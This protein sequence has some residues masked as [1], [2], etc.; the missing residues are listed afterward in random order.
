MSDT[1]SATPNPTEETYEVMECDALIIGAGP[2]GL[3][4]AIR[5]AQQAK[6]EGKSFNICVLEKGAEVGAH[7]LAGAVLE[8][9]ALNELLPDWQ[10]RAKAKGFT[11]L[12]NPATTDHFLFLTEKKGQRLPTP[13]QMHNRGN[14]VLSL[15]NLCRFLAQEAESLGVQIF[16]GFPAAE[17]LYDEHGAVKGVRTGAFGIA[18]D[19]SKKAGYQPPMEMH[20]KYTLIGEGCRGSLTKAL[21][22]KFGLRERE[23]IWGSP[24]TYGLGVKELWEIPAEKHTPG[25]VVHTIGWP[26]D[27]ATYGGGFL[28]HMANNQVAVG[29]VVGLDYQN[30]TLSPFEEMQR[31]KTH[32]AIREVLEGG[33]RIAY[34]A[35]ALNEGGL[36]SLPKLTFP[37]G[38]LMGCAAGFLNV[39][40]IKGIHNAMWSG[41]YLAD[42][43]CEALTQ[44]GDDGQVYCEVESDYEYRVGTTIYKELHRARN[45]RPAMR[46]GLKRGLLYAALDT[47]IL[48]GHAPWTFKH[49]AD[50]TSLT[51]IKDVTNITYPKPDGTLTF[52]L[53]SSVYLS[54]TN[55]EEDQPSHLK[56]SHSNEK[57]R[58]NQEIYGDPETYYCPA[59]VYERVEDEQGSRIHVNAQNCLHCKTCDIKDPTQNIH[60]VTPEGGGGPNY[61][62]M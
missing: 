52:D 2:S 34:G 27:H 20:A 19:G 37:G 22:E 7:L 44:G 41:I 62:N 50:H 61:P 23:D 48:R 11:D 31:F 49:H 15:G 55:H 10:E 59:G 26:L 5:L 54:N 3:A 38:A 47:Y 58:L 57:Q 46:W 17:I 25:K 32:P 16:P 13:P 9:A 60:W 12:L 28:Y 4:A 42:S 35:R 30:P 18:K 1:A 36:Q 53:L 29:F 39:P 40:K 14:F 45:I 51:P 24:Q 33:T 43:V 21:E 8:P 56:L 6:K